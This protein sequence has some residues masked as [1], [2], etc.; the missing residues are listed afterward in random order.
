MMEITIT[1]T[2]KLSGDEEDLAGLTDEQI[3]ELM[4]ENLSEFLNNV[5]WEVKR[6]VSA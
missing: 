1:V 3:V 2:K 4:Y 5:N 6:E